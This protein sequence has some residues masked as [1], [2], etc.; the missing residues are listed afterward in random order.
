MLKLLHFSATRILLF[1]K[2]NLL[3]FLPLAPFFCGRALIKWSENYGGWKK[4]VTGK[5]SEARDDINEE[6]ESK[7]KRTKQ[8]WG[9]VC[10]TS[11]G[12]WESNEFSACLDI[13]S[14]LGFVVHQ[15]RLF[16]LARALFLFLYLHR[17]WRLFLNSQHT[18]LWRS[19]SFIFTFFRSP[20]SLSRCRRIQL[21]QCNDSIWHNGVDA[22]NL[23]V[24]FLNISFF[25]GRSSLFFCCLMKEN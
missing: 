6:N 22:I 4:S 8:A 21:W 2:I 14:R 23:A 12:S 11:C 25:C 16:S 5:M 24:W 15:W 1:I 20:P 17:I 13:S 3:F 7:V 18:L 10:V 9:I 19:T